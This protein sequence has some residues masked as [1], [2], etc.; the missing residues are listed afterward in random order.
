MICKSLQTLRSE[1]ARTLRRAIRQ[2]G[3]RYDL[4]CGRHSGIPLCCIAWY[5]T[6]WR[7]LGPGG[8]LPYTSPHWYSEWRAVSGAGYVRCPI[9]KLLSRPAATIVRCACGKARK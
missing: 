1:D 2:P 3:L 7:L 6:V 5:V 8:V 4:R 9:C